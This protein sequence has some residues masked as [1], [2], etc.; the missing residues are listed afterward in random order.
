MAENIP[1]GTDLTI[2]ETKVYCIGLGF[3][4]LSLSCILWLL[5][6]LLYSRWASINSCTG[7]HVLCRKL[8]VPANTISSLLCMCFSTEH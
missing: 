8:D 3:V 7:V 5:E 4:F 6:I 1:E 2:P